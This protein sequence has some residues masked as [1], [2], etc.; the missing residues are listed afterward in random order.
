MAFTVQNP[1][2]T[3]LYNV[4]IGLGNRFGD[5]P[6]L[7]D[8]TRSISFAETAVLASQVARALAA[9][10]IEPGQNVGIASHDALTGVVSMIA[11]WALGA[12]AVHVDFRT[13]PDEK[14]RLAQEFDIV[15]MLEDRPS[16]DA[17]YH[18]IVL[19]DGWQEKIKAQPGDHLPPR[20]DHAPAIISL[21]SGTTGR[22]TGIVVGHE[23]LLCR[24]LMHI[25]EGFLG[26]GK[27]YLCAIPLSYSAS[28]NHTLVRMLDGGTIHF[29]PP[30]FSSEELVEAFRR[31]NSNS[32][33]IVPTIL[34]GLMERASG[35]SVPLLP[36]MEM[37]FLS[38]AFTTPDEKLLARKL[39]TP[40][41]YELY[42]STIAG[43]MAFLHPAD[44]E[45]HAELGR[46]G[47][48][49]C[50]AGDRR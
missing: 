13:R 35:K 30:L 23:S 2:A 31:S 28:R 4:F 40:E 32:A 12:S 43:N 18:S 22:P 33:Y 20:L 27:R 8:K 44:M 3:N 50:A 16:R 7:T 15:A 25:Q 19:G 29:Q 45:K 10:G 34:R 11:I 38:G 6:A 5:R 36:D 17:S 9:E 24:Y 42:S 41:I 47:A 49:A 14:Q 39:V 46:Q 48:A 37:L 1:T 21:T 26:R